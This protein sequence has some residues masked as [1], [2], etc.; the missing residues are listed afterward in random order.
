M[1]YA[2][3]LGIDYAFLPK[4]IGLGVAAHGSPPKCSGSQFVILS[5]DCQ[6]YLS[7]LENIKI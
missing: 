1:Y 7:F 2:L 5:N 6:S 4:E 3:R